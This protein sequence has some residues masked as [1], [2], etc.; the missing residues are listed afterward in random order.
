VLDDVW[1]LFSSVKLALGLILAI[2]A[3]CFAGALIAQVPNEMLGNADAVSTWVERI[4]P[5]YGVWTDLLQALGVFWVF[6]TVWFRGLLGLLIVNTVICTL[7]R[8]PVIWGQVFRPPV[9]PRDGLFERGEPRAA[10]LLPGLSS[11]AASRAVSRALGRC[12]Y[13]VLQHPD[14][15]ET[16]L[17]ADRFRLSRFATLL[18][19]MALVLALGAAVVSGPLGYFEEN[20]FAVP[21]GSTREVG[22]GTGLVIRVDDFADEY[23]PDGRPKDYRSEAVLYDHGREVA[24]QTVRVNEPLIYQGVRFHQSYFGSSAVVSI[25]D[26]RGAPL[27]RDAVPLTWRSTDG[28]RPVGYFYLPAGNLHVY[29]V[30]TAGKGDPV[31]R[32]GELVVEAYRGRAAAPSYRATL[33]QREPQAVANMTLT[34]EREIPFTGL[35]VVRDP[36]APILW[37]ASALFVVG[38]VVTFHL[39]PRTLWARLRREPAGVRVTLVGAGKEMAGDVRRVAEALGRDAVGEPEQVRPTEP[40]AAP[41][42]LA[43]PA[44]A[45]DKPRPRSSAAV[46]LERPARCSPRRPRAASARKGAGAAL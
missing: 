4:R 15:P 21:V 38:L 41:G 37:F 17:Y 33:V 14:A 12:R 40:S 3:A 1:A 32:P 36:G 27:F 10:V 23:Y 24:R 19:H 20:G 26:D 22:H 8:L 42:A 28:E 34:F 43:R 2:A 35:R 9:W 39:R 18:T 11:P 16:Y 5:R 31:I 6:Q 29:L 13:R 30:G 44:L 25:Q 45:I 46:A 7:N